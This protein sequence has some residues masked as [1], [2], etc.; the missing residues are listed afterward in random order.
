M[1]E[2]VDWAVRV[3]WQGLISLILDSCILLYNHVVET[4]HIA[5]LF[6]IISIN[7]FN[8]ISTLQF[9]TNFTQYFVL[10]QSTQLNR[11][12]SIFK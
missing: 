5:F 6:S 8:H 3:G 9:D 7:S 2:V 12:L 10:C 4:S 11:H 1:A